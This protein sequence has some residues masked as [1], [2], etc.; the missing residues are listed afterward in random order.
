M[1]VIVF[2]LFQVRVS[3][4]AV[5]GRGE[6]SGWIRNFIG[7]NIFLPGKGNLRKS[8]FDYLNLFQN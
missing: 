4:I 3:Q 7:G 6:F 5:G 2:Y 8:D 1:I